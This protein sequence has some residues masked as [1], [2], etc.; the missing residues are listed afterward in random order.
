M[1]SFKNL[2]KKTFIHFIQ[3]ISIWKHFSIRFKYLEININS[4]KNFNVND[5][6]R[7]KHSGNT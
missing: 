3:K 6:K 7:S 5:T 4:T 2:K 1:L